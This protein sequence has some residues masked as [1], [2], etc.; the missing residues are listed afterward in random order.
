MVCYH[1]SAK[2]VVSTKFHL[3][4]P[5]IQWKAR[6]NPL[7]KKITPLNPSDDQSYQGQNVESIPLGPTFIFG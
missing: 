3:L 7:K 2:L 4:N 6:E 5:E 1:N